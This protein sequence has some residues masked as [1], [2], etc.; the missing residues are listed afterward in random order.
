MRGRT[1]VLIA[2]GFL[3]AMLAMSPLARAEPV[4]MVM[5]DGGTG[6]TMGYKYT[7]PYVVQVTDGGSFVLA[8]ACD[9]LAGQIGPGSTW[10]AVENAVNPQDLVAG[11]FQQ[12]SPGGD[13]FDTQITY[14]AA[15]LLANDI[16]T[17][18]N[19][20]AVPVYD[21]TGT[22]IITYTYNQPAG[23]WGSYDFGLATWALW[24]LFDPNWTGVYVAEDGT[25]NGTG[26]AD[27]D[28]TTMEG[29]VAGMD[30]S[31]LGLAQ[32]ES[33]PLLIITPDPPSPYAQEFLAVTG[34]PTQISWGLPEGSAVPFLPFDLLVLFGGI[35]LV[36]KRIVAN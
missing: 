18:F 25:T 10:T 21:S 22:T 4:N 17:H 11:G 12:F 15:G 23:G 16:I 26:T 27:P 14:D 20:G 13:N 31:Y 9:D 34:S 30:A 36:R 28:L 7:S 33:I 3:S 35:F 24:A 2:G 19:A 29:L 1:G 5:T 32:T 6:Y 8:L